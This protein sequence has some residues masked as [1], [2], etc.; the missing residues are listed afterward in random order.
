MSCSSG[1]TSSCLSCYSNTAIS[2]SIYFHANT[3][4]CY[5][6]CPDGTYNDASTL[7]CLACDTNCLTC[8]NTA[9]N[10]TKC[11][12][13]SSAPYLNI[14][15]SIQICVANCLAKMY[16]E[17][18]ISPVTCTN[19]KTPCETCIS[20]LLCLSCLSGF[21]YLGNNS[22]A[23]SCPPEKTVANNLTNTCDN[24]S[25]ICLKCA[26][27]KNNCTACAPPSAYFNGSCAAQCPPG[28]TLAPYE[29]VCTPCN[30][31][32]FHC[33][34]SITNCTDCDL[35]SSF[36]FF[37]NYACLAACPEK[38]YNVTITGSCIAC[39]SVSSL[40]CVNCSSASTCLSCDLGFVYF[41][42]NKTCV[43]S[44]A[45]GFVNISGIA[46]A[47]AGDCQAC[48]KT[49]TNCTACKNNN[50]QNNLCVTNCSAGTIALSR[51]CLPC[52]PP[53]ATCSI[54][55]TNCNSC[56][57]PLTPQLYLLNSQCQQNC[58][59]TTYANSSNFQCTPCVSPCVSCSA[60]ADCSSCIPG[61]FLYGTSCISP[62]PAGYVGVVGSGACQA[63]TE[64]CKTC[65][66]AVNSCLTCV[67]GS[68]F[69]PSSSSCV[70]SCEPSLFI[71]YANQK[72][73]GC[74]SPCD[75]CV[76]SSTTCLSCIAGYLNY[77][78][79]CLGSCPAGM[80]IQANKTC[81]A[82]S[83]NCAVCTSLTSCLQCSGST[84]LYNKAC[85]AN[86]PAAVAV[87]VDGACTACST[88]NC[89]TCNSADICL[90]CK[91]GF[92]FFNAVC[93]TSCTDGYYSNGTHCLPKA[94]VTAEIT[95]PTT[96]PVPFSIAGAVLVIACLMSR[97][98]FSQTYLSGAIYSF[99][100][101]LEVL[102]LL[103]FLYLYY[104]GYYSSEPIPLYIA[105][106][107]LG[108]LYIL[109]VI[110]CLAQSI[111]LCYEREFE[112]WRGQSGFHRCFYG[113]VSV[114]ALAVN[115]KIRNILFCK[116]FTFKIFSAKLDRV[117]H[118]KIFNIFS[119]L[120]IVH[121]G[122][123]IFAAAVAFKYIDSTQQIFYESIDVIVLT[124]LNAV[125]AFFN[126]HKDKD[127]F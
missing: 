89:A 80:F 78:N 29:G 55:Q 105:L 37:I 59:P 116:L 101:V 88:Q 57:N 20:Q 82:C 65:S 91:S 106:G 81:V 31:T 108:Y 21:F 4:N 86:C 99:V 69:L 32:C 117:D 127:F 49:T 62:C 90:T 13:S 48:S 8:L 110:A 23:A 35:N 96:F 15:G 97:L 28:G 5:I 79:Q 77:Q 24:C 16:P 46:T 45:D 122:A 100:G 14:S 66:G 58:S 47:C 92:L 63:C 3:S 67:N 12:S 114:V 52:S 93:L 43:S 95:A 71:D 107:A 53:C 121:S 111:F 94:V 112:G 38:Y 51:V 25:S 68:Y 103:Y 27:T 11:L 84:Y 83:S 30:S 70:S 34:L 60:I 41:G 26:G 33:S 124:S 10:C 39:A 119:L 42:N 126:A 61:K 50:L 54:N 19:C 73:V 109:N 6:L 120:S 9:T 7:T 85:V 74:T 64:N 118:F 113:L 75:T 56:L 1:N 72:C 115:H 18:L 22:C 87:I 123:A 40:N 98:Q 17:T 102:A 36:P 125:L 44:L 104:L 76:N 2:P